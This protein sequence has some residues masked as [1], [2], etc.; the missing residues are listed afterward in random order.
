MKKIN[1]NP[2]EIL[3]SFDEKDACFATIAIKSIIETRDPYCHY[4]IHILYSDLSQDM[5]NSILLLERD[6]VIIRFHNIS[7][8]VT[9]FLSS[10]KLKRDERLSDYYV[11]FAAD[12]FLELEKVLYISWDSHVLKDVASIYHLNLGKKL[13][14]GI[15]EEMISRSKDF[16][17]YVSKGLNLKQDK[18]IN[19]NVMLLNLKGMRKE[20]CM[21]SFL[22]LKDFYDF[23]VWPISEITNLVFENKIKILSKKYNTEAIYEDEEDHKKDFIVSYALI[24][25]PWDDPERISSF[26]FWY[27]ARINAEY[28]L[29]KQAQHD[30]SLYGEYLPSNENEVIQSSINEMKKDDNYHNRVLALE[31]VKDGSLFSDLFFVKGK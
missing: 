26:D 29:A 1:L 9:R 13:I 18:Y 2:V 4:H 19:S 10:Y 17:L 16:A 12:Y 15:K 21:D 23:N 11:F 24:K 3:L 25:R 14:G 31:N 5:M 22:Q 6:N 20:K 30:A 8:Y 28:A 7:S 27:F